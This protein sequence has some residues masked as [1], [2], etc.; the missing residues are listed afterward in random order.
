MKKLVIKD[1]SIRKVFKDFEKRRLILKQIINNLNFSYLI[2]F[3]AL[4]SINTITK[5]TSKVFI[6][7][8][9]VKTINK[10]KFNKLTKFSRI[11]FLKLARTK[12]IYNLN[13]ISW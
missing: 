13:K 2:R 3:N 10:K 4:N 7:N 1:R 6:S 8:R 12:K 5:K 9:C 11:L